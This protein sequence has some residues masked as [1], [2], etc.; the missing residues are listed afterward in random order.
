M[1]KSP[2]GTPKGFTAHVNCLILCG[3][4][5][6]GKTSTYN[7]MK[8]DFIGA[9]VFD[10]DVSR[11]GTTDG[12]N[13][14][15]PAAYVREMTVRST[16]NA[17]VLCTIDQKVRDLLRRANLFYMVFAPEFPPHMAQGSNYTPDPFLKIEYMK[18]FDNL[19]YNTP[20]A[21]TLANNGYERIIDELFKDPMPHVIT[22]VMDKPAVNAAWNAADNLTRQMV[23]PSQF[24]SMTEQKPLYGGPPPK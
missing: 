6:I 24:V 11:Y 12:I 4:P 20:A 19:G 10:M 22:P 21:T 3:F 18:R 23:T 8:K 13:V 16:E 17:L 15:D 7:Q 5:A 2:G 9:R 14:E 1:S